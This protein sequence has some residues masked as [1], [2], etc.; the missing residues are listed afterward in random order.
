MSIIFFDGVCNLCNTFVDWLIRRDLEKKIF[1]APLQGA[2]A[3]EK[4]KNISHEG[5]PVGEALPSVFYVKNNRTYQK[6]DAALH[7]IADLGGVWALAR[8]LVIIPKFIRD[9]IYDFVA[10]NRYQWFG[11]KDSCRLPS[12]AEKKQ[13]LP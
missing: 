11:K 10:K 3:R 1:Y 2:T 5:R 7:V 12:E 13:F 6:S 4:L 9:F 8:I